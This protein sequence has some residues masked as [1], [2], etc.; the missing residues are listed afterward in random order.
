METHRRGHPFWKK[1]KGA[2]RKWSS[3]K[4]DAPM[5]YE[6]E[7]DGTMGEKGVGFLQRR[8]HKRLI[9]VIIEKR[10]GRQKWGKGNE[11]AE[12]VPSKDGKE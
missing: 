4:T 8:N 11:L 7:A 6:T 9:I 12:K 2:E 3:G 5:Q 1:S 10:L